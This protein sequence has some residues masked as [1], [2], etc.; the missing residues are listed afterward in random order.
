MKLNPP[1][2]NASPQ[3]IKSMQRAFEKSPDAAG[4]LQ[5]VRP[6]KQGQPH[7]RI[8]LYPSPKNGGHSIPC[9][10]RLEANAAL[11][12][13]L[14]PTID[15]YRSQPFQMPGPNGQPIVPDFALRLGPFYAVVDIKPHGR[16]STPSVVQRMRWIRQKLA[17]IGIP[18]Y[19]FTER[20]LKAQP[21][22]QIREAL[23]LG[24]TVQ[25]LRYQAD[26]LLDRMGTTQLTVRKLR[27]QAE[28]HGLSPYAVEKLALRGLL[29]F[30]VTTHWRES[31]LLGAHNHERNKT[32]TAGWGTVHDLCLPL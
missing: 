7:V 29:T 20:E 1:G 10:G 14:D 5:G 2:N 24:Q 8:V 13:E 23:R 15:A 30:P 17:A 9:E 26:Q 12:F 19:V 16:L 25:I 4:I 27:Q 18:H 6:M 28:A 22:R 21:H 32:T 3:L 31:T 11:C